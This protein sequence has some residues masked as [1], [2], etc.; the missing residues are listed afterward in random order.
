MNINAPAS[1][2][3]HTRVVRRANTQNYPQSP[4]KSLRRRE[5]LGP[6]NTGHVSLPKRR[7]VTRVLDGSDSTARHKQ[8]AASLLAWCRQLFAFFHPSRAVQVKPARESPNRRLEKLPFHN[9]T[10]RPL[11]RGSR[12]SSTG[13]TSPP[14]MRSLAA[15]R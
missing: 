11:E 2:G 15:S 8:R 14:R 12:R 10:I 5:R 7:R 6:P 9:N 4:S 1:T 3:A 13:S